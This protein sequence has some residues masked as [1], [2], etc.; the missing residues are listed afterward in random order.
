ME[1]IQKVSKVTTTT[2]KCD[3]CGRTNHFKATIEGCEKAHKCK[4]KR[5]VYGFDEGDVFSIH[6]Q[7]IGVAKYCKDCGKI[8][9]ESSFELIDNQ[10]TLKKIYNLTK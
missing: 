3:V 6:F 9:G 7:V 2:Y 8:L 5:I 4:H 10:E 1:E